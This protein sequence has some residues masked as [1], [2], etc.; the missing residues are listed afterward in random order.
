LFFSV[1]EDE[2]RVMR[3]YCLCSL[4]FVHIHFVINRFFKKREN[5][6]CGRITGISSRG[7]TKIQNWCL[8]G[9]RLVGLANKGPLTALKSNF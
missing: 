9:L 2:L 5:I 6:S 3:E 7:S 4:T 1:S 8:I